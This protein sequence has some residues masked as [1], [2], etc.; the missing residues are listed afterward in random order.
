MIVFVCGLEL[1]WVPWLISMIKYVHTVFLECIINHESLR[2][3]W[4]QVW[5]VESN[6]CR[7]VFTD[8][9]Q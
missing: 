1:P 2:Y 7:F 6:L 9:C 8:F 3:F 4:R 5:F